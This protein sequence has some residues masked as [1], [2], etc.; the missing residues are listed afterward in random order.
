[1]GQPGRVAVV[2]TT[3]NGHQQ[4]GLV[5]REVSVDPEEDAGKGLQ[6]KTLGHSMGVVL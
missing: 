5:I 6:V 1:M 4:R 2:D 3:Q